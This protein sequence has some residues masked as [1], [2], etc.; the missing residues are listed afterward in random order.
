MTSVNI[1]AAFV[2]GAILLSPFAAIADN[3]SARSRS[4]HAIRRG[5]FDRE[6][7]RESRKPPRGTDLLDSL[8]RVRRIQGDET[9]EA[10]NR[11]GKR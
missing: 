8:R 3:M 11:S 5:V 1:A 7:R 10:Y 4:V 6:Q 2:G 9:I